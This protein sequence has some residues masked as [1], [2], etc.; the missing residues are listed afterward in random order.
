[1][2]FSQKCLTIFVFAACTTV[3]TTAVYAEAC[4]YNEAMMAFQQGNVV[5]GQALLSM[6]AKDGDQRAIALFAELQEALKSD[7]S[8]D[9]LDIVLADVNRK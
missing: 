8:T 7:N 4:T 2:K 9:V 5:R 1:M 6:A 3:A